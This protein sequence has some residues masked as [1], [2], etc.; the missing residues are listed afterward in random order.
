MI[1]IDYRYLWLLLVG[2]RYLY[3]GRNQIGNAR[4]CTDKR[5]RSPMWKMLVVVAMVFV[6]VVAVAMVFVD[7]AVVV[8]GGFVEVLDGKTCPQ[9]EVVHLEASNQQ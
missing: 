7:V 3:P 9:L 8:V 4:G 5:P 6:V 2:Y 1:P